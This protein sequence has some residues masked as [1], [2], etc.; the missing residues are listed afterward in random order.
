[1]KIAMPQ[2]V[3]NAASTVKT[4]ATEAYVYSKTL[5]SDS[6]T[7]VK[8]NKKEAAVVAGVTA[9]VIAGASIIKNKIQDTKSEMAKDDKQIA[10]LKTIVKKQAQTINAMKSEKAE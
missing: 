4:K 6:F 3:K 1:M 10:V 8:N 5:A 7:L 2:F 9:A